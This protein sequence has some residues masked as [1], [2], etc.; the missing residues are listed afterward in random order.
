MVL[1]LL[2]LV[3]VIRMLILLR[4]V[5]N[6]GALLVARAHLLV[7]GQLAYHCSALGCAHCARVRRGLHRSDRALVRIMSSTHRIVV[8]RRLDFKLI[9]TAALHHQL[10]TRME[11]F[12]SCLVLQS[13]DFVRVLDACSCDSRRMLL[14]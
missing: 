3:I 8:L 14:T 13:T 9:V 11:L 1:L 7:V 10:L 12:K 6:I 2:L 4:G 5:P